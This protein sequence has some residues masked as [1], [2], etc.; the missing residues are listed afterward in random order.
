MKQTYKTDRLVLERLRDE[1]APFIHELLNTEGWKKFI[2]DRNVHSESD[3]LEYIRK[4]NGDPKIIFWVVKYQ[5]EKIGVISFIKRVYLEHHDI[6]FAFLPAFSGQGFAHE[7]A[8][9][10]MR[11]LMQGPEYRTIVATTL[12]DNRSSIKLLERLGLR[13]KEE[14][15]NEGV[16]L[17]LYSIS[18]S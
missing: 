14:I 2:G 10:V 18:V 6:G 15:E 1:D 12:M 9:V 3:A 17:L 4:I 8:V 13:Y 16:K 7:A 5:G 11:D